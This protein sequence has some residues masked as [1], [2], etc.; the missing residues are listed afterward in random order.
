MLC[1][2]ATLG[3]AGCA[4]NP[5]RTATTAASW[6]ASAQMVGAAWL[7]GRVPTRYAVRTLDQAASELGRGRGN[8]PTTTRL[9]VALREAV[10]ANDREAARRSLDAVAAQRAVLTRRAAEARS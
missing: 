7:D 4:D 6:T 5:A 9:I 3:V 1:A 10:A 2:L 8:D